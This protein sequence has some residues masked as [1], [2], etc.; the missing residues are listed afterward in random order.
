MRCS[1]QQP[2]GRAG[3][4][5]HAGLLP[6]IDNHVPVWGR[7]LASAS[8][9]SIHVLPEAVTLER[10]TAS[11]AFALGYSF[12]FARS[13]SSG[14]GRLGKDYRLSCRL[15]PRALAAPPPGTT[16]LKRRFPLE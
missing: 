15:H 10:R 14:F 9:P 13:P 5:D 1:R 12:H 8:A 4:A 7:P 16:S 11:C 2:P 3:D 6:I